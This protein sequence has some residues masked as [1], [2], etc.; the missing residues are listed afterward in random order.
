MESENRMR[1]KRD[2]GGKN[3]RMEGGKQRASEIKLERWREKGRGE[4]GGGGG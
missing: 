3:G 2:R 1:E 4:G